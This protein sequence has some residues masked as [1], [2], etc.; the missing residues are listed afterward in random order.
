[1][2][3]YVISARYW[4]RCE[5]L[6]IEARPIHLAHVP[7]LRTIF[8]SPRLLPSAQ[9][10]RGSTAVISACTAVRAC[11]GQSSSSAKSPHRL[12]PSSPATCVGSPRRRLT[13]LSGTKY[14]QFKDW[15]RRRW[16]GPF[17]VSTVALARALRRLFRLFRQ[18]QQC[19][20]CRK[21]HH[22]V[23]LASKGLWLV[24]HDVGAHPR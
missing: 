15:A 22:D 11:H 4:R 17:G 16:T 21:Y 23:T 8:A 5:R 24:A 9:N 10:A 18:P 6:T 14:A 3:Y 12:S 7:L 13:L 2:V 1:M 19:V 20:T